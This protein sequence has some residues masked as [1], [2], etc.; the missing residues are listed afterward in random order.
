MA[1]AEN[2]S[3]PKRET[4]RFKSG[5]PH[6]SSIGIARL[7]TAVQVCFT[8]FCLY[9][10]YRFYCFY[11]WALEK[12]DSYVARP[13][14]VEGFLPISALLGLKRLVLTGQWD[15]VHPAGLTI[16]IAAIGIAF[17]ARKGFCGWIC[18]VGCISN[19]IE[20]LGRPLKLA[21]T[22]PKALDY[23]LLSLKYLLLAFFLYVVLLSMDLRAIEEFLSSS[24]NLAADA[25]MLQFFL[26]PSTLTIGVIGFLFLI[27]F[28][29]RNFW[30]RYL[31]PYGA[32]LGMLSLVGPLQVRRKATRCI[33]CKKCENICPASIRITSAETLC[34]PECVGCMECVEICPQEDCLSLQSYSRRKIPIR[35][36]PIAVVLLFGLFY[37]TALTTGH[38]H[39]TVPI[40]MMKRLYQS[41][42]SLVHP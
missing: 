3:L 23:T 35:A 16:L 28:V 36:V 25:K 37:V 34:H 26:D 17:L 9:A 29:V 11:T 40:D 8:L 33:D 21:D 24:Y 39:T 4:G 18:P 38:W 10:G 2:H 15:S 12:S 32:L 31:C 14:S 22:L 27:S 5:I 20:K 7:R 42:S 41:A 13:P 1:T 30:C 6:L 19:L